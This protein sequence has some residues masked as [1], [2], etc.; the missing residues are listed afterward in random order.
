MMV[1]DNLIYKTLIL[2]AQ[3]MMY[4]LV[5]PDGLRDPEALQLFKTQLDAIMKDGDE[6]VQ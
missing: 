4:N 6:F 2:I 3:M 5:T 1:I